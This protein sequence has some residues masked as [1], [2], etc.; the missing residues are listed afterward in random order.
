MLNDDDL[1]CEDCGHIVSR[2]DNELRLFEIG[3]C[4]KCGGALQP[5]GD[6]PQ[7]E[8]PREGAH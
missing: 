3:V 4:Q 2:L 8:E 1:Q 6:G 5:I 7:P